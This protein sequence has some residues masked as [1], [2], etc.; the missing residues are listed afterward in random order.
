M[1]TLGKKTAGLILIPALLAVAGLTQACAQAHASYE[2]QSFYLTPTTIISGER[3]IIQAE[4]KNVNSETDTYNIP[5]MVNGVADSRKS[6]TLAPGQTQ[7]L[8]FELTRSHPGIYKVRVGER[9]ATLTVEKPSP[10]DFRLSNLEIN[11]AEANVCQT[12][13]ITAILTNVGNN[14]GSYTAELKIDGATNQ[15]QK[16]TISA[17]GNCELCFKVAKAFPG[18]Y[19]V[20]LGNLNG[21]FLIKEPPSPVFDVPIAP[22]C[23][24]ESNGSCT[25]KG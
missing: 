10:A 18:I 14:Q 25:P 1:T 3:S 17:G 11:P 20:S 13:V 24:P 9:E 21:Q 15:T 5:L 23:P 8:T 2:V 7:L 4:I 6:V 12:V 19:K 22:P 16:L